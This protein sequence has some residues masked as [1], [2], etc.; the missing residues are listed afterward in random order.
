MFLQYRMPDFLIAIYYI[1]KTSFG[2]E[3]SVYFFLTVLSN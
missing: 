3:G 1:L 2:T